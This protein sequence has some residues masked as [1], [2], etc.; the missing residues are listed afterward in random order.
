[1]N[2]GH[3]IPGLIHK[4]YKALEEKTDFEI[5]GTGKPYREFLYS[6]DAG[7]IAQWALENYN[8]PEPLIVS[9]DEEINI[10]VLAQQIAWQ[11]G[12][13]GNIVFNQEL[14]GM[15]RKPSDNSKFKSL[16]PNYEFVT[17]ENGLTRTIAWFIDNYDKG[18]IRL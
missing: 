2:S 13:K 7:N 10:A 15:F 17:I 5:W 1:M 4:C 14:D 6:S 16:L 3:V 11:M 8:E 18:N 9:P 12:F